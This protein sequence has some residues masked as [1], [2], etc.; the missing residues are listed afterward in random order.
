LG[1]AAW[2]T[3]LWVGVASAAPPTCKVDSAPSTGDLQCNRVYSIGTDSDYAV[4]YHPYA[5]SGVSYPGRDFSYRLRPPVGEHVWVTLGWTGQSLAA[6]QVDFDLFALQGDNCGSGATCLDRSTSLGAVG[7][8]IEEVDFIAPSGDVWINVDDRLGNPFVSYT[9]DLTVGCTDTCDPSTDVY[10]GITCSADLTANTNEGASRVLD[11]YPCGV[12]NTHLVQTN[13]EHIYLF[14]PQASGPVTFRLSGMTVDHDLYVLEAACDPA[15]CL[16][17]STKQS[18]DIDSVTFDAVRGQTY[19]IVVEAYRGVGPY[20]LNFDVG[21]GGCPEDCDDG[22]DNDSDGL[23]DCA[24]ADA[25]GEEPA[26]DCDVDNDGHNKAGG[27]CGGN[28]CRDDDP[29]VYPGAPERCDSKDNDCDGTVDE[30]ATE[31]WYT[32]A[33]GDGW[34]TGAAVNQC[35]QPPG[36]V[37]RSGDCNDGNPAIKPD[38]PEVCNGVDDDCDGATDDADSALAPGAGT[39]FYRDADGDGAGDLGT[40]RRA[41]ARPTGFVT[42]SADCDDRNAQRAPGRAESCDGLDNDCDGR[43]D[44]GTRCYD[45]DG[46]GVTEDGGDCADADPARHPRA[47]EV[48]DGVDQDCDGEVDQGTSCSDDDG[49]GRSEDQGDCHDGDPD[50]GPNR[51]EVPDNGVDDDCDGVIDTGSLDPDADGYTAAGGDCGPTDPERHPGA[52]ET[53]DGVDQ[54]C[55]GEVDEGTTCADDDG[56][57]FS[58]DDGDCDDGDPG[59]APGADEAVNGVDDDCDG[60]IDNG[61]PQTDDDGDGLSEEEGD[62]DDGN[63]EVFP[64]QSER[65]NGVDDDCDG[66]VDEPGEDNDRDGVT[67]AEGDCDDNNGWARPGLAEVCGD[68]ADNDCDGQ[69]DEDCAPQTPEV[70]VSPSPCG[71]ATPSGGLGLA[72]LAL[73]AALRRRRGGAA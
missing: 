3:G 60:V 33:D 27:G 42:D 6:R 43:V 56:D 47:V 46:D 73:L 38:A 48:C 20:T 8:Q 41:C 58:E 9:V 52:V 24:D 34:G 55:D 18:R 72:P 25:C 30:G 44:E 62:C 54:D 65:A 66:R 39:V 16:Q 1:W 29:S 36:R 15:E 45:D 49:D 35:A 63:G 28:D 26:C 32:D 4:Q 31:A 57:G 2:L 40:T 17:A 51:P 13:P 50:I 21:V 59:R 5:C 70:P 12:P 68:S 10:R 7:P 14:E 11:F 64:G 53:C 69:A 61:G 71:C 19:Y 37:S 23:I 22:I 67:V